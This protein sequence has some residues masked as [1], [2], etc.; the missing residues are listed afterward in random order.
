MSSF[1]NNVKEYHDFFYLTNGVTHG[2]AA[3]SGRHLSVNAAR[4]WRTRLLLA[5][6]A[7]GSVTEA[8]H[9]RI[10]RVGK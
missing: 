10:E 3:I 5:R 4:R 9:A 8:P 7:T 2:A 1:T 6:D